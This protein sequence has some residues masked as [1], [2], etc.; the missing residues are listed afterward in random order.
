MKR[1]HLHLLVALLTF[2]LGLTSPALV[3]HVRE[4]ISHRR[5]EAAAVKLTYR[6]HQALNEQDVKFLGEVLADNFTLTIGDGKMTETVVKGNWVAAL[7]KTRSAESRDTI[8]TA[9]VSARAVQ[10]KV[11]VEGEF[12][13]NDKRLDQPAIEIAAHF[14]HEYAARRGRLQLVATEI[15]VPPTY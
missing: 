9:Q 8:T 6:F 2:T 13:I 4:R 10:G 11:L 1:L 3:S 14:R 12:K 5:A 7:A 15:K